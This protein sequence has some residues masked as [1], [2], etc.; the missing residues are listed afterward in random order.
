MTRNISQFIKVLPDARPHQS[1]KETFEE[2]E[3]DSSSHKTDCSS[4]NTTLP[5]NNSVKQID[6]KGRD[7]RNE[8]EDLPASGKCIKQTCRYVNNTEGIF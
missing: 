3:D 2:K 6:I 8:Q 7:T 1:M 4:P 5:L